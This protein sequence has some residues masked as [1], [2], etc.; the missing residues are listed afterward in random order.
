MLR[1]SS[2]YFSGGEPPEPTRK[3]V[4]DSLR[5]RAGWA[6]QGLALGLVAALLA[7]PAAT[8]LMKQARPAKPPSVV[9]APGSLRAAGHVPPRHAPVILGGKA[10]FGK[11][12]A[13]PQ[14]RQLAGWVM[15]GYDHG[16]RP[17]A[18]LDKRQAQVFVFYPDGKLAGS[19][20]VLLGYAAG[21]DSVAGI[22]L[23]PIAEVRPSERTTAAG[24]F[25][26][27]PGRNAL[28]EDVLWVDYDAA[29]SMHRVRVTNPAER[30]LE[31][32]ASP[33]PKDNRISFGCINMPVKFFENQLWPILGKRGGIVYVLP[34][35]KSMEQVFGPQMQRAKAGLPT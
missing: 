24:R 14:A 8:Y 10:D 31:R 27:Q 35:K 30:R 32:L 3:P 28:N 15:A 2:G 9:Q 29:V 7:W 17:F 21:D 34:E 6:A 13:S 18:I 20:P 33:T 5:E 16:G 12:K 22:G 23:R 26:A 25:V 11:T 1:A 4:S 19:T